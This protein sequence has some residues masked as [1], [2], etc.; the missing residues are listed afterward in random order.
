MSAQD[1]ELE[2]QDLYWHKDAVLSR[3]ILLQ[4]REK[5]DFTF[6]FLS[7]RL[8]YFF[9]P[10]L[11]LGTVLFTSASAYLL[12]VVEILIVMLFRVVQWLFQVQAVVSLSLLVMRIAFP[13]HFTFVISP[14]TP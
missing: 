13:C 9:E 6:V 12:R 7:V 11:V 1:M 2:L 8:I 4:P 3:P 5:F 14:G 10:M